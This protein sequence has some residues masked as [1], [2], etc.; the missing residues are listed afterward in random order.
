MFWHQNKKKRVFRGFVCTL[1]HDD[2]TWKLQLDLKNRKIYYVEF[3]DKPENQIRFSIAS[4]VL[5]G[6]QFEQY[7]VFTVF[8]H[9]SPF[10]ARI[11]DKVWKFRDHICERQMNIFSNFFEY[12]RYWGEEVPYRSL[13]L[14]K[15]YYMFY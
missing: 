5:F 2:L 7:A 10:L 15:Q 9:F 1:W 8:D 6:I 3:Y 13:Q 14:Y 11:A 4:F 12:D